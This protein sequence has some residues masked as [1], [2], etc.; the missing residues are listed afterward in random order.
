MRD[1]WILPV[2]GVVE[3]ALRVQRMSPRIAIKICVTFG[4]PVHLVNISEQKLWNLEK[5]RKQ[6][7]L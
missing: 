6:F 7:I 2:L 1:L 3:A 4:P 5:T